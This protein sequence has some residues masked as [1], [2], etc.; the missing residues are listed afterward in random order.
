VAEMQTTAPTMPVVHEHS[1]GEVVS[2][3]M[4]GDVYSDPSRWQALGFRNLFTKGWNQAWE[5][6]PAGGGGV[7]RQ[8]WI[9]AYDG[10]FLRLSLASF[11]WQHGLANNSDGYT[12]T[13]SSYMP[14]N[15]RM[16]I[17]T[18]SSQP[19]RL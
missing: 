2:Q 13:L 10:V 14:L 9:N 4:A 3:S 11:A 19:P 15:Q 7:R 6:P 1:V 12:G 18:V 17:R 16:E 5:S 8:G